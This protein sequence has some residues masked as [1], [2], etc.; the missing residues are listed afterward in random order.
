LNSV[1][2]DPS[3]PDLHHAMAWKKLLT[4]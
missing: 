2:G 4:S 3:V 1:D